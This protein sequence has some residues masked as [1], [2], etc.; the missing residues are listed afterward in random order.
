MGVNR[1]GRRE[2]GVD[3]NTPPFA[4]VLSVVV[5]FKSPSAS[6]DRLVNHPLWLGEKKLELVLIHN[7]NA[8]QGAELATRWGAIAS[9]VT[10]GWQPLPGA[11][12]ARNLG[13]EK[14]SG[15]FVWFV[16]SDDEIIFDNV[17]SL[18]ETLTELI[19]DVDVVLIGA[20]DKDYVTALTIFPEWFLRPHLPNGKHSVQLFG[21][22]LFQMT[23]PAAWNKIFSRQLLEKHGISFS[24]SQKI[25]DLS[26]TYGNLAQAETV[27]I[28]NAKSFYRYFR[29]IPGSLQSLGYS[30]IDRFRALSTLALVLLV[31]GKTRRTW[32]SFI[33]LGIRTL[34]PAI[35]AN[36]APEA[37]GVEAV[38]A[39]R[40]PA[41]SVIIP[42]FNSEKY[43]RPAINSVLN[44]SWRGFEL[45]I[46]DD[47]SD[48]ATSEIAEDAA[49]EDLRVRV[50]RQKNRGL[51]E[52]RNRG[53]KE[54]VGDYVLF[55][56]SDD[57]LKVGCLAHCMGV[58]ATQKSDVIM[59][60]TRPFSDMLEKRVKSLSQRTK[61]MTRFYKRTV[62]ECT[63]AGASILRS[64]IDNDS[65]LQSSCL[66][67]IRKETLDRNQIFF[68]PN[69]TMEDNL[70]TPQLLI[71]AS[72]A[73]YTNCVLHRR[74][75]RETSLSYP[76][77]DNSKNGLLWISSE[78]ERLAGQPGCS[79][80]ARYSLLKLSHRAASVAG[81]TGVKKPKGFF[82]VTRT[83]R[84]KLETLRA[85]RQS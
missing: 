53:L 52:A 27:Y 11:G 26:F 66:Y 55:L 83:A 34:S 22:K 5:P 61:K 4:P 56:D 41:V 15:H 63:G 32:E 21:N 51:S 60:N 69:L 57:L 70:F 75:I 47:G 19:F 29:N 40:A 7:A 16:D 45:L 65:Y 50:I 33:L 71:A 35:A 68:V 78:L 18:L 38:A 48:D 82:L 64:H 72:K 58:A 62:G 76:R 30:W 54:A 8:D 81:N 14:S 13:L 59:F 67:L 74:R 46:I 25:N 28:Y 73:T 9:Q 44:Q 23:N 12:R 77:D 2:E 6:L 80:D 84:Q 42:A 20:Q 1:L 31:S 36:V 49:R 43:L 17:P 24:R 79:E 3:K 37:K 10:M 85:Q 39:G